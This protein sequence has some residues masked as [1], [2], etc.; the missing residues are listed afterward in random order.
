ML[1]FFTNASL[2]VSLSNQFF[3]CFSDRPLCVILLG[4]SWRKW[5]IN[6]LSAN[7]NLLRVFPLTLS[8]RYHIETASVMKELS[9]N[10]FYLEYVKLKILVAISQLI[11]IS[12]LLFIY[13][14]YYILFMN[15][16][17][18]HINLKLELK[19]CTC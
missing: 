2:T 14:I 18:K 9:A 8:W 5:H 15:I 11:S 17:F 19:L 7:C 4:K 12:T 13:S 1:V 6:P 16:T 10:S 3:D